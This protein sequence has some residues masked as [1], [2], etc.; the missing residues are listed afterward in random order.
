[1]RSSYNR[2]TTYTVISAIAISL[3]LPQTQAV[4]MTSFAGKCSQCLAN[5]YQYC[6]S[7]STCTTQLDTS[8]SGASTSLLTACASQASSNSACNTT[9][10]IDYTYYEMSSD[11]SVSLTPGQWCVINLQNDL[12]SDY[13]FEAIVS[14]TTAVSSSTNLMI[15]ARNS[16]QSDP[17]FDSTDASTY[18]ITNYYPV[19]GNSSQ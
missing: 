14:W 8:C 12:K 5:D 15:F 6:T 7:T 16:S 18:T 2:L 10:A 9:I 13:D 11:L 3:L 4:T 1:M 19:T 17:L